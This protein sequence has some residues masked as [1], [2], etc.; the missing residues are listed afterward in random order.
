[1]TTHEQVAD[2]LES[3]PELTLGQ[4]GNEVVADLIQAGTGVDVEES[5]V[6]FLCPVLSCL[7]L[8]LF[9]FCI[10]KSKVPVWSVPRAKATA[11]LISRS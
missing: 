11:L 6:R 7:E 10:P 2:L 5:E 4:M 8:V 9:L 1:M 3:R